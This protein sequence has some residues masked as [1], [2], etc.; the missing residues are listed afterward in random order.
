M[1]KVLEWLVLREIQVI[2]IGECLPIAVDRANH[3]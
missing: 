1:E 2:Y 3:V